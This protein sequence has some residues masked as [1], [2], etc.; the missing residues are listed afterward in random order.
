MSKEALVLRAKEQ[1]REH[2]ELGSWSLQQRVAL[3]CAILFSQGHDSGLA[4]Q[5]T[6]RIPGTSNYYTQR[7]G[8]GFDE[9]A[10]SNLLMVDEDLNVLEGQ[11]MANPANRFH[12]W[13]YRARPQVQCIV[14]THP[15][16]ISALSMLERPLAVSHM[17][18]CMLYEDVAFVPHWPGVPVGNSEGELIAEALGSKRAVLLAHH[19]LVV[20]CRSME[21]ACVVAIQCERAARLQLLASAAGDIQAIA[22]ELAREAHDWILQER[23]SQATF[24]YYA[25]RVLR[26][27]SDCLQ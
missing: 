13:I 14:H 20:A 10:V 25:R 27:S 24:S 8:L 7:M 23:R 19:G 4:G 2:L 1:M 6:A 21:E 9:V 17:D 12:T 18:T 5:I 15:P 3:T 16:H 22:P 26:Q 11:G